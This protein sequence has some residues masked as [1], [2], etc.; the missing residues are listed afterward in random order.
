MSA[1]PP[2]NEK[3]KKAA[4]EFLTARPELKFVDA[5]LAD[6]NGVIR[7][8]RLPGKGAMKV[9]DGGLRLPR[10][11]VGVDI[12]G[13]DVM[14]NGLIFETGDQDGLCLAAS[15]LLPCPWAT[16]PTAQ[17]LMMMAEA[18]GA[19]FLADPRQL[20]IETT[21]R[22]A[23]AGFFPVA[24]FE[25]EFY[26]LSRETDE[27]GRP[28]AP[29][30]DFTGRRSH[31]E[32]MYAMDELDARGDFLRDVATVCEA[33]GLALDTA[34][35]ESGPSQ[36]ELNLRHCDDAVRA[37]DEA[38]LL[39]RAIKGVAAKHGLI[40]SFMAKPF[41]E[42]SGS[43]MHVHLSLKDPSGANLFDDGTENG[44]A[45]LQ[46]ALA[47]IIGSAQEAMIFFAPH[48]NS[49]RRFQDDSHA[50]TR[51]AW[52]YENRSAAMRIPVDGGANRRLEHRVS[53]ADA[54]PYLVLSALLACLLNGVENNLT[55]PAPVMG[56][57]HQS[58]APRLPNTW[59][60][61]LDA[62]VDGAVLRP[63]FGELFTRVF[64]ACKREELR[65]A[66]KRVTDFE[67]DTYLQAF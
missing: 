51:A 66:N 46:N 15:E 30:S 9:F 52:G 65:L 14:K 29:R 43:G 21:N 1:L 48:F 6:L 24:A 37:A 49:Y 12:W 26:L 36:F 17:V 67:Y 33:Q 27:T 20:L 54:N 41:G 34:V 31:D 47:G 2:K 4:A 59:S 53:G 63:A 8:K 10:S 45:L 7:G 32:R 18:D 28:L 58:D 50:P 25:M 39:R 38:I 57:A 23:A 22:C 62:F 56:D 3:L 42:Y 55:P 13:A 61:A 19:P 44:S 40:A 5:F 11:L 35:G 64:S 16:E 60:G